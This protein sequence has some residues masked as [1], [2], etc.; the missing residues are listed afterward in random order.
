MKI[1][2]SLVCI[3]AISIIVIG[4]CSLFKSKANPDYKNSKDWR[5]IKNPDNPWNG[6]NSIAEYW[7]HETHHFMAAGPNYIIYWTQKD[8]SLVNIH[9]LIK[10]LDQYLEDSKLSTSWTDSTCSVGNRTLK[11]SPYRIIINS[12]N[13]II[14]FMID[15]DKSGEPGF[16]S[17]IVGNSIE[18]G[19]KLP[20][21]NKIIAI[22]LSNNTQQE[23]TIPDNENT[24]T[25][26]FTKC[27]IVLTRN[28]DNWETKRIDK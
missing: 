1:T 11:N 19:T 5:Q 12:I 2:I 25:F 13:P 6:K 24:Y 9:E 16:Y 4:G 28:G 15:S 22:D 3:L 10:N 7:S 26:K 21:G 18:S 27:N 17:S 20:Y 23:A 8:G 14:V